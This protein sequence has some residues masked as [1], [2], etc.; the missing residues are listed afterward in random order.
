MADDDRP[1][2]S[3]TSL[4]L[5]HLRSLLNSERHNPEQHR[6]IEALDREMDQMS[7]DRAARDA[8]RREYETLDQGQDSPT[9]SATAPQTSSPSTLSREVLQQA[10]RRRARAFR[11]SE[12][13]RRY[14]GDRL[15]HPTRTLVSEAP[16]PPS[17][18][19]PSP[20]IPTSNERSER[21]RSKRR[22]LD[23]GSYDEEPR[24]FSYGFNG[25]VVPGPLRMD[26]VSCDGGEYPNPHTPINNYPENVLTD[27]ATVY[28][29]E[30][31]T[32]NMLLKHVGGMPFT[33][34]KIVVKAPKAG[35]DAP[36]QN[37]MVF[38]AMED[39]H[40]LERASRHDVPWSPPPRRTRYGSRPSHDYMHS[41]RSPLR[42][43]DRSRYLNDPTSDWDD[44]ALE[45]RLVPGF[46]VSVGDPSDEEESPDGTVSPR[47]W[48]EDDYSLRAYVDRYRPVYRDT[49]RNDNISATSSDSEGE[50]ES[51]NEEFIAQARARILRNDVFFSD[52]R[53]RLEQRQMEFERLRAQQIREGDDF[54][55]RAG[56]QENPEDEEAHTNTH[57]LTR[58][59]SLMLL[60][61]DGELLEP[62]NPPNHPSVRYH[63]NFD[64]IGNNN[65]EGRNETR[66]CSSRD[67]EALAPHARFFINWSKSSTSIKFDPPV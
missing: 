66:G 26:I 17:R 38:I 41:A 49:R 33:L 6:A 35:F 29:T 40:L 20:P 9:G 58:P 51:S 43:I 63:G 52:A 50:A 22:K 4:R 27:D 14:A 5:H 15:G 12:R 53:E 62:S 60:G 59:D 31:N 67:S 65:K 64:S 32:C 11:P 23:D 3:E 28:C 37:G 16:M 42:S 7:A 10:A 46:R 36:L 55:G 34:T 8:R 39:D 54:F 18:N 21:L 25:Q 47:P 1:L 19:S 2:R 61:A 48:P 30:S 44:T 45:E 24:T 56:R 57:Q 13:F